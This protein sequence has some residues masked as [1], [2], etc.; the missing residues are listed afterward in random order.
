MRVPVCAS[1]YA[2]ALSSAL[3]AGACGTPSGGGPFDG[4]QV[5]LGMANDARR[6]LSACTARDCGQA[7]ADSAVL[8]DS[9][10]DGCEFVDRG[11]VHVAWEHRLSDDEGV[12]ASVPTCPFGGSCEMLPLTMVGASDRTLWLIAR[13]TPIDETFIQGPG[14]GLVLI[15]HAWDGS[16]LHADTL[17]FE[18]FMQGEDVQYEAAL[19]SGRDGHVFVAITKE[20]FKEGWADPQL[21]HFIEE[22]GADGAR[23]GDRVVLGGSRVSFVTPQ[24]T[25]AGDGSIALASGDRLALMNADRRLRWVQEQPDGVLSITSDERQQVST[26]SWNGA[27]PSRE[28]V[29]HYDAQGRLSWRRGFSTEIEGRIGTDSRGNIVRIGSIPWLGEPPLSETEMLVQLLSANGESVSG[30]RITL[31]VPNVGIPF[32]AIVDVSNTAWLRVEAD[33]SEDGTSS[34]QPLYAIDLSSMTCAQYTVAGE[35]VSIDTITAIPGGGLYVSSYDRSGR[36]EL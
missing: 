5:S 2:L 7:T 27:G 23:I 35:S 26:Y 33:W 30:L 19:A 24:L 34:I 8:D 28:E 13:V 14:R 17:D 3:S 21:S 1:W 16:L 6:D 25:S 15:H 12:P 31:P 32:P 22:F 29:R 20:L 4:H 36:L 10:F 9:H 18:E 11:A